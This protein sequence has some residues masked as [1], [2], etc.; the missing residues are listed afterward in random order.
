MSKIRIRR[1]CF[2]RQ[3][4]II[5]DKHPHC[6]ANINQRTWLLSISNVMESKPHVLN[7]GR[8]WTDDLNHLIG[9]KKNVTK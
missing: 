2:C 7:L 8:N 9:N 1:G 4:I 5:V 3:T 6:D